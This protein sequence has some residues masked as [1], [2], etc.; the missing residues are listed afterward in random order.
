MSIR[1]AGGFAITEPIKLGYATY[2]RAAEALCEFCDEVV[3]ICGRQ[4]AES[5]KHLLEISPKVKII[6]TFSWPYDYDYDHMRDHF[7]LIF[8]HADSDICLKIDSDCVFSKSAGLRLREKLLKNPA[9]DVFYLGR[10]N[11]WFGRIFTTNFNKVLYAINRKNLYQKKI[12]YHISNNTGMN[13][14]LFSAD[15]NRLHIKDPNL[16]PINYNCTF[17]D[18]KQVLAKHRTWTSAR[19]KLL[20]RRKNYD[21]IV[22]IN[23]CDDLEVLSRFKRYHKE[24]LVTS[25]PNFFAQH[26]ENMKG[27]ISELNTEQWGFANFQ[28]P[29]A[30][31]KLYFQVNAYLYMVKNHFFLKKVSKN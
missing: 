13:I 31:G 7:Q 23:D 30:L 22:H 19:N 17:M 20:K 24:K 21:H 6:N 4:E 2:L 3:I 28:S 26:P 14:P 11:Y 8:E 27:L 1:L 16:F 29:N 9:I 5:E 18:R 12:N 10:T 25:Y 15:V